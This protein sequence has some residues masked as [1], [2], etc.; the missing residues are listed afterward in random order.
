MEPANEIN[1]PFVVC[2]MLASLDGKID[3][4]FFSAQGSQPALAEYGKLRGFYGCQATLYGT[5]TMI[6]SYSDG[7]V[8]ELL[9]ISGS[10]PRE[11]YAASAEE[12]NYIVSIDTKGILK[13][14]SNYIEKKG[15]SRAY[16]IEVMTEAVSD[17]YLAYLRKF[18]ISYV[19]AGKEQLDCGLLLRKL[20]EKFSIDRLMIAGGGAINWS[21]L[22]EGLI[23]E[24][25]LIMVP[26]ADGSSTAVSI[27]EKSQFFPGGGAVSFELREVKQM[28][29]GSLWL[30][31]V[32]GNKKTE[33]IG[34]RL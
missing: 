30:R 25:S 5:T 34:G 14:S 15:R 27:F 3:G 21:F 33:R 29:G 31:Y 26:V 22:Q 17:E 1:K 4:E 20:K 7:V 2:H 8:Q 16:V 12:K 32:P 13:W 28:E 9:D 6:G 19:F 24:L 11:D 23:D 10:Y 18:D